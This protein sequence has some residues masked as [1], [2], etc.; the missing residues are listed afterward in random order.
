MPKKK[1]NF[2]MWALVGVGIVLVAKRVMKGAM[3][4]T[5]IYSRYES[6]NEVHVF[7]FG[8]TEINYVRGGGGWKVDQWSIEFNDEMDNDGN[9]IRA[10]VMILDKD[11]LPVK[12]GY[13]YPA[14]RSLIWNDTP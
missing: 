1:T 8:G 14:M 10:N 2:L 3:T 12:V 9:V 7:D 11:N 5:M 13:Y 6:N 4:P